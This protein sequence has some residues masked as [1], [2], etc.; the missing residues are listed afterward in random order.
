MVCRCCNPGRR[1]VVGGLLAAGLVPLAGGLVQ[2]AP[3][4]SRMR[5]V[6]GEVR[7]N[8]KRAKEGMAVAPGDRI[9]TGTTGQATFTLGDDGFMVRPV[10]QVVIADLGRDPASGQLIRQ[11]E[12]EVGGILSV[13]GPKQITLKTPHV[14]V[15][16]RGTAAYLETDAWTTNVCVCYG[17]A[18]MVPEGAPE[19]TEEVRTRHHDAPRLL[20]LKDGKT[21]MEPFMVKNH[22]DREL[23]ELERLFGRVPPFK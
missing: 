21:A 3:P 22:T 9:T 23:V 11:L 4:A 16:I 19:Q 5:A 17:H 14:N 1:R 13:F 15:G 2:A 7:V 10:T 18:V 20:S 8:G 12:L 6:K